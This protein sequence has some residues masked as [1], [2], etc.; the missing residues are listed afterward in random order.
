[1]PYVYL[2][3]DVADST[4]TSNTD[5]TGLLFPVVSGHKYWFRAVIAYTAA[6]TTTGAE[7]GVTV[8]GT[9][10]LLGFNVTYPVADTLAATALEIDP[11]GADDGTA[12]SSAS[13]TATAT[14]LNIAIVEG[15]VQPGSSGAAQFRMDTEVGSSAITAKAGVTFVEYR[16]L[17]V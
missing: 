13:A 3:S 6:A 17:S 12:P 2:P 16:D 11:E 9:E 5:I 7:F 10:T 8:T 1:M 4:V 14:E 15:C